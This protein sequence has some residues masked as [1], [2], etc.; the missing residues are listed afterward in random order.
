[1]LVP[2]VSSTVWHPAAAAE[3]N[4]A[5]RFPG[6]LM[7]SQIN[8]RG[9]GLPYFSCENVKWEASGRLNMAA[10]RECHVTH[11]FCKTSFKLRCCSI[12]N[13]IYFLL[14]TKLHLL[15][16]YVLRGVKIRP[17]FRIFHPHFHNAGKSE[18]IWG[19]LPQCIHRTEI[20]SLCYSPCI[21][22]TA[23]KTLLQNNFTLLLTKLLRS[24]YV[25]QLPAYE[26][27]IKCNII[28]SK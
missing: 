8:V 12:S 24:S 20:N 11:G 19:K 28:C 14:I 23:Y 25:D 5:P 3:R 6:S 10:I 21:Q 22:S 4:T 7:L 1:M 18:F 9:T 15:T 17:D 2:L 27:E 13:T 16:Y 26:M